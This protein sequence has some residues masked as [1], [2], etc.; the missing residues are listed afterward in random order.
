[1]LG[2]LVIFLSVKLI[3]FMQVD[4]ASILNDTINY[5]KKLEAR[6]EELES[7]MDSAV[8]FEARPKRNHPDMVEQI[9]D[10]YDS[11]KIDNGRKPWINKR[12]A[13]DIDETDLEINKVVLKDGPPLDVKVSIKE[14]EVLIEMRC[15]YREFI[16]LDI[17][18]A[19]N[20]LHLD[21]YSV[22]S[23]NLDGILTVALKSKVC[24]M[25]TLSRFPS[26]ITFR[27]MLIGNELQNNVLVAF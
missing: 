4:K 23:T 5:L 25:V 27:L 16:L 13:S 15:P 11:Q 6:V 26:L 19:I 14:K 10:N 20:N 12:K 18:D 2:C 21:A 7:C 22:I 24:V 17:M 9:F 8:D 1:M 3:V